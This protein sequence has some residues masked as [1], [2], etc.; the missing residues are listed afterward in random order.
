MT[1]AEKS[2]DA[3]VPTADGAGPN[4]VGEVSEETLHRIRIRSGLYWGILA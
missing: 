1:I 4:A 3:T 2:E